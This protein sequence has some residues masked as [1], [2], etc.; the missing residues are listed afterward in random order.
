MV[1]A[2]IACG[3]TTLGFS[4]HSYN[5]IKET[6]SW[7][8]NV[9]AQR[10]YM[11]EIKMLKKEY[12]GK[13]EILL[14]LEQDY[15]SDI[16]PYDVDY[17]IGSVHGIKKNGAYFDVDGTPEELI[18]ACDKYYGGNMMGVV[19]EYYT[20]VST[21]VEK[22][23]CD[24]IGHFDLVTKFNEKCRLFDTS[25][26][27]YRAVALDALDTLIEKHRIFEINTGAIS[28]GWRRL[29]YPEDFLLR[30]LAEKGADV[31]INSDSHH[32]NTILFCFDDAVEYA[33]SCGIAKLCV[34]QNGKFE[35]ISI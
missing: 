11:K 25:S 19:R 8:M 17:T 28:R 10:E 9:E 6:E 32:K 30:R 15:Y 23:D 4:G 1:E 7:T 22:T 35:K 16:T 31:M 33:K 13:I 3:C 14:G 12:E 5:G 26:K 21:V 2:A 20:L 18:E 34:Y 27:E 29:P 24:I